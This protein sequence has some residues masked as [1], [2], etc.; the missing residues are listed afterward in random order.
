M[1]ALV[2]EEYGKVVVK[3][4]PRPVAEGNKVLIRIKAASICGSDVH[5]Y[6][7][8][9][10]RRRP[11]LIMG[12]E[13]SG[14]VEEMGPLAKGFAPGNRVTFNS[15]EYCGVC[16]FCARGKQNMCVTAK[17]FGVSCEAYHKEGAMAEYIAVPDYIVYRI[18][19]G[20]S[21]VEAA[22]AEPLAIAMH[23]VNRTE[24]ALGDTALV[25]GAGTIGSMVVKLLQIS[26]CSRVILVDIDEEKL[27]L[28]KARGVQYC[29][30]SA[31]QDVVQ[32]VMRITDGKGADI[33][34]EAVGITPTVAAGIDA[35]KKC[36]R[37]TL[38]GNV[39]KEIEFPL[40][41]VVLKELSI[42]A[43]Y[44]CTTEYEKCLELIG[45]RKIDVMDVVSEMV[46]IERGQEMFQ[47]LLAAEKGLIKIVLTLS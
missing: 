7:G 42:N 36:G 39:R 12:H 20:V 17:V 16:S 13:A 10:G 15:T 22:M 34:F 9:S 8:S 27:R 44:A 23:A 25:F 4:V 32:E 33:A 45:Q 35:L 29:I 46:P 6:D 14:V 47:R 26:G 28:A 43:S 3:D 24:I 1:K 11:P 5:G 31:K 19:E 38:L 18:P 30:N 37:F 2:L 21:F 40:Q 41:K